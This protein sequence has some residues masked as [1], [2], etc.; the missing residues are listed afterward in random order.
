MTCV[1]IRIILD[2]HIQHGCACPK[3]RLCAN[4]FTAIYKPRREASEEV[5]PADTLILDLYPP[6]FENTNVCCL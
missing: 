3:E 2:T 4:T 1:L 5:S 6:D